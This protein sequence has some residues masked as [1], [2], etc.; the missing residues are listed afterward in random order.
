MF[1]LFKKKND[2]NVKEESAILSKEA[3][4][5]GAES[6]DKD[7]AIEMAGQ[8]LVDCLLYTSPSPRD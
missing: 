3:I 6:V 5:L 1:G 4:V 8:L 7:K 2:N